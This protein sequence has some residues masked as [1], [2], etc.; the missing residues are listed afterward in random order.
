MA[1]VLPSALAIFYLNSS[2]TKRTIM[3][4][5]TFLFL[6]LFPLLLLSQNFSIEQ[7]LSAPYAS[8]LIADKNSNAIAWVVNEPQSVDY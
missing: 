1:K 2:T 6:F 4:K 3:R 5:S 8:N 7:I